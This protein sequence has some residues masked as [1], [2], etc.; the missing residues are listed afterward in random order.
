MRWLNMLNANFRKEYIE[1]KRYMA[2]TLSML[3]T[4]YFV[5]LAMF[6]GIELVGD[7]SMVE[8]NV[9]YVI[10]SYIFW[11]LAMMA[12]QGIGWEIMT[13]AQRGTLE[14]LYMSPMGVSRIFAARMIGYIALYMVLIIFL[15]FISMATAG[16]W[17]NLDV[18]SIFPILILTLI[19]M[20]GVGFM[21]A[22]MSII[23]KQINAFLQIAQFIFMAL[24][25][26]PISVA[27]YLAYAPFVKGVDLVRQIMMNGLTLSGIPLMDYVILIGNAIVYLLLGLFLFSRCEKY[28]MSKGL[29][30]HY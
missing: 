16:T 8:E 21:I 28:A 15:L 4:F 13:E 14:Q 11:F 18:V 24:T 5:F 29:L 26:V 1:L 12:M 17:L 3:F 6:L 19:S 7:P 23:F 9:Q 25:F 10:V 20:I 27:P 22:G 2:N 30:G